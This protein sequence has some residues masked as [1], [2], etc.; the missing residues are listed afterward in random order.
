MTPRPEW[1]CSLERTSVVGDT[2]KL[3]DVSPKNDD[4]ANLEYAG[5]FGGPGDTGGTDEALGH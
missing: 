5:A 3:R 1:S 4:R 2:V